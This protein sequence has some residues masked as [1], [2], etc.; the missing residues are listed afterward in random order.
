MKSKTAEYAPFLMVVA[1]AGAFLAGCTCAG[2]LRPVATPEALAAVPK[3]EGTW[4]SKNEGD[5]GQALT[6]TVSGDKGYELRWKEKDKGAEIVFDLSLVEI[7]G[8]LFFD[9][10]FRHV[11]TTQGKE[12]A[13]DLGVVPIHFLGRVWVE[14]KTVRAGLLSYTWM[15]QKVQDGQV[16]LPYLEHHSNDEDLI[17]FNAKAEDL[18]AFLHQYADD[19]DAFAE[20]MNFERAPTQ[21]QAPAAVKP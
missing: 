9:A 10:A 7:E 19:P 4:L 11:E 13:Y 17:L 18:K 14:E 1:T 16:K 6:V 3:I 2:S 15:Q 12:T 5:S 20:K 21:E 8:K